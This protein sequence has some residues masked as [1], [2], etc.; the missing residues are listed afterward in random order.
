MIIAERLLAVI[1]SR[2][3]DISLTRHLLLAPQEQTGRSLGRT[4]NVTV[5]MAANPPKK[6]VCE[7]LALENHPSLESND[8]MAS[9]MDTFLQLRHGS[10]VAA[11]CFVT[12][13]GLLAV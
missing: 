10:V 12:L 6:K 8:C 9:Q 4:P 1:E 11:L 13:S 2:L 5:P 3:L 7:A